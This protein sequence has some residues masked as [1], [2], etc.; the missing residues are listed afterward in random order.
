MSEGFTNAPGQRLDLPNPLVSLAGQ[1]MGGSQFRIVGT[2]LQAAILN[3]RNGANVYTETGA[4]S[5][6][7]DGIDMNTNMGGGLGGL[8]SPRGA[9]DALT[10]TT[11]IL[12][13]AFFAT[14]LALTI[15]SLHGRPQQ[16]SILDSQPIGATKQPLLPAKPVSQPAGPKA[17][18]VPAPH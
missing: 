16:A 3:L 8:F 5:W 7:S 4:M 10:R 17:P 9:G 1:T 13:V 2:T 6:M 18:A 12:A 14:S 15:L 11:A